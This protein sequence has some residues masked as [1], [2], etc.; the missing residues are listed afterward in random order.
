MDLADL[1]LAQ[2]CPGRRRRPCTFAGSGKPGGPRVEAT[3]N[4]SPTL[5]FSAPES[6][7]R[8]TNARPIGSSPLPPARACTYAIGSSQGHRPGRLFGPVGTARDVVHVADIL[9]VALVGR[10]RPRR[11]IRLGDGVIAVAGREGAVWTS[12]ARR[13]RPG[14]FRAPGRPRHVRA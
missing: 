1:S 7:A 5:A 10:G 11:G 3:S 2:R 12:T 6:D 4:Q 8:S 13:V 14:K 9:L